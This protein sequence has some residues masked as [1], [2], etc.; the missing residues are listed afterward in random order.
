MTNT[1]GV[2]VIIPFR[3]AERYIAGAIGSALGQS[4]RDLGVIAVDDASTDGGADLVLRMDDPRV[5][6]I[7]NPVRKGVCEA[8][9]KAMRAAARPRSSG[10]RA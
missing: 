7:R 1:T 5:R 6:L 8:R 4:Y 10:T 3:N 2:S 9:N